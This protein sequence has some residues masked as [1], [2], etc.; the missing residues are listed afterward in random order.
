MDLIRT[1]E[2]TQFAQHGITGNYHGG[3]NVVCEDEA[4][5]NWIVSQRK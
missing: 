3:G 4:I 1:P 5:L 2:T